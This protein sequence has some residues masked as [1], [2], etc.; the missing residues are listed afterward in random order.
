MN[1]ENIL[2]KALRSCYYFVINLPHNIRL[3]IDTYS[4]KKFKNSHSGETCF[5]IGN[6]PSMRYSDLDKI[7]QLGIS[8]FACNKIY[9]AFKDTKWRPDYYFVSDSKIL[10]D[11]KFNEIGLPRNKMFFPLSEKK[12]NKKC[13][14]FLP[15]DHDWIKDSDFSLDAHKGVYQCGTII[16]EML[17]FAYYMGFAKVYIIGVD[18]SYNMASVDK[19]EQTFVSGGNNYFIKDYEKTGQVLNLSSPEANINGFKA[20]RKGFE[21]NGREIYNATRGGKLEVFI[22]KDLDEVFREIE[23]SK[24]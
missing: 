5:I 10:K 9:L 13:N 22:R 8:S 11:V 2:Y 20:A 19:K 7:H 15:L 24:K 4:T 1:K 14:Y 16:G 17:Q 18:F 12:N 23:E 3:Y 6:G 21:S